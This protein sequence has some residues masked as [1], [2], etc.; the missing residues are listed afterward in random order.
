MNN[1]SAFFSNSEI[2]I[3]MSRKEV[4]KWSA[5]LV[6]MIIEHAPFR[7]LNEYSFLCLDYLTAT[8]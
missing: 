3:I 6:S 2:I 5:Q 4:D 7:L 8:F 1:K